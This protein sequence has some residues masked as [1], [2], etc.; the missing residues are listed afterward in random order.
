MGSVKHNRAPDGAAVGLI[1]ATKALGLSTK[2]LG[3]SS[4]MW[5]LTRVVSSVFLSE[6]LLTR[7]LVVTLLA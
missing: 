6:S 2:A 1:A 5:L 4:N 7:A 3:L